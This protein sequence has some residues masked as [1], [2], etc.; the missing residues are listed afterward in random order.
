MAVGDDGETSRG[1]G[2]ATEADSAAGSVEELP[3]SVESG[4]DGEIIRG[5]YEKNS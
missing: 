2:E 4:R 1:V 5:T 3:A